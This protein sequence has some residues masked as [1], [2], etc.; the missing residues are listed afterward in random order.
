MYLFCSSSF[1]LIKEFKQP[2]ARLH[3][4][5]LE[6]LI[7]VDEDRYGH[8]G[9][10]EDRNW[11]ELALMDEFAWRADPP[12]RVPSPSYPRIINSFLSETVLK[13]ATGGRI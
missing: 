1:L 4:V 2:L 11:P 8:A 6:V 9:P 3:A 12:Q 13:T 5:E 7:R 10:L